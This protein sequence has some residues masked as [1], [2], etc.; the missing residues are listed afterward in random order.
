MPSAN[1]RSALVNSLRK[2]I[3]AP[4]R[5]LGD[6]LYRIYEKYKDGSSHP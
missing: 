2:A 5:R 4:E 6:G 3:V 1:N